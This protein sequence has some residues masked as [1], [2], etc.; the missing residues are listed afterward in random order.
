MSIVLN[1]RSSPFN[2]CSSFFEDEQGSRYFHKHHYVL[3]PG[4]WHLKHKCLFPGQLIRE[5]YLE[6]PIWYKVSNGF[7]LQTSLCEIMSIVVITDTVCK[8][9][10][11]VF[12]WWSCHLTS[13]QCIVTDVLIFFIIKPV[14]TSLGLNMSETAIS[15]TGKWA[16]ITHWEYKVTIS[17]S[18]ILHT[19]KNHFDH[20]N[21][22]ILLL[23]WLGNRWPVMPET[24]KEL[25]AHVSCLTLSPLLLICHRT[26]QR[27]GFQ[28]KM[29][30]KVSW[31]GSSWSRLV[32]SGFHLEGIHEKLP[33][34]Q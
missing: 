28:C 31:I 29:K 3:R 21:G 14:N 25:L 24:E 5:F 4:S 6:I 32:I 33:T 8:H 10:W 27:T 16:L 19:M 20:N 26:V 17:H 34:V 1:G 11:K 13:E 30:E 9:D 23:W 2:L 15:S 18:F 22:S 12:Y 7:R